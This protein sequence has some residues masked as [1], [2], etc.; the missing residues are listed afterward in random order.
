M[1]RE[2]LGG[3]PDSPRLPVSRAPLAE[4][5]STDDRG[6]TP[7]DWARLMGWEEGT[8]LISAAVRRARDEVAVLVE[9]EATLRAAAVT[10]A[11]NS[12]LARGMAAAVAM[13][14]EDDWA[15]ACA[16]VVGRA[17][18]LGTAPED[19]HEA[20][21]RVHQADHAALVRAVR[22][23]PPGH[24]AS[25]LR[26]DTLKGIASAS[27]FADALV[28]DGRGQLT[29]LIRA[30]RNGRADVAHMLL[31]AGA[32]VSC[33]AGDGTRP[34]AEAC[35]AGHDT[36]AK[37]LAA[38][39]ADPFEA[40]ADG[41]TPLMAAAMSDKHGLVRWLLDRAKA[42]TLAPTVGA[43]RS[44]IDPFVAPRHW[45]QD[46]LALI[47]AGNKHGATA[48]GLA[49]VGSL[50][51]KAIAATTAR[52]EA[53]IRAW[54][55]ARFQRTWAACTACGERMANEDMPRH[56]ARFCEAR[57]V[58]TPRRRSLGEGC[59]PPLTSLI[60]EGDI[61]AV[62]RRVKLT[63][64]HRRSKSGPEPPSGSMA[65][66]SGAQ[67]RGNGAA[68][69]LAGSVPPPALRL[70]PNQAVLA[71]ALVARQAMKAGRHQPLP[72]PS[73]AP[74][75]R[76]IRSLVP[77]PAAGAAPSW[78]RRQSSEASQQLSPLVPSSSKESEATM[79][80]L[81]CGQAI[82]GGGRVVDAHVVSRCLMRMVPCRLGCGET[83]RAG[84][85]Q[86]HEGTDCA[87][88]ESPCSRCGEAVRPGK[89]A[90][91]EQQRCDR[92][93]VACTNLC[94]Q[95]V[96]AGQLV[97]HIG[98]DCACRLLP[99]P[100]NCGAHVAAWRQSEHLASLC[101]RRTVACQFDGCGAG[102]VAEQAP[103]HEVECPHRPVGCPH[104]GETVSH[105][106]AA[107][108]AAL[109]DERPRQCPL[110]CGDSLPHGEVERHTALHCRHRLVACKRGCGAEVSFVRTSAHDADECPLRAVD[111]PLGCGDV[112]HAG[113][114]DFHTPVCPRRL[115][116]CELDCVSCSRRASSWLIGARG[117]A[118]LQLCALHGSSP[119]H[120]SAASGDLVVLQRLA[121]S[122]DPDE[123]ERANGTGRVPL[124]VA[125]AHGQVSAV[126]LLMELGAD[127]VLASERGSMPLLEA[128]QANSRACAKLLLE[129][130]ASPLAKNSR[131]MTPFRLAAARGL[132]GIL[133]LF[134][135]HLLEKQELAS[136]HRAVL[137][138]DMLS[139][140]V[141]LGDAACKRAKRQQQSDSRVP[142]QV[143]TAT[144]TEGE[145]W[146]DTWGLQRKIIRARRAVEA[147]ARG[148]CRLVASEAA[149]EVQTKQAARSAA[150]DKSAPEADRLMPEVQLGEADEALTP[151][152]P[153]TRT[154]RRVSLVK[155]AAVLMAERS[156]AF[157]AAVLGLS[158]AEAALAVSDALHAKTT[159]RHTLL[160]FAAACGS[161]DCVGL[162]LRLGASPNFSRRAWHAAASMIQTA[163]RCILGKRWSPA[164][165][166][167]GRTR[168]ERRLERF[169]DWYQVV[170]AGRRLRLALDQERLPLHEAAFSGHVGVVETLLACRARP[171]LRSRVLAEPP[172]PF[173]M[174]RPVRLL[175][176][177]S[178]V[179]TQESQT[180][181]LLVRV[182]RLDAVGDVLAADDVHA[183]RDRRV[184]ALR[185][186]G[187]ASGGVSSLS[188]PAGS[189]LWQQPSDVIGDGRDGAAVVT[190]REYDVPSEARPA[191]SRWYRDSA[192]G[193]LTLFKDEG[194]LSPQKARLAMPDDA[195]VGCRV[196]PR[197]AFLVETAALGYERLGHRTFSEDRGWVKNDGHA[198]TLRA[199][200][201]VTA[202]AAVSRRR[203]ADAGRTAMNLRRTVAG[204][205]KLA[206][207]MSHALLHDDSQALADC[208]SAGLPAEHVDRASG[209]NFAT[210]A[211]WL[212]GFARDPMRRQQRLLVDIVVDCFAIEGRQLL[213]VQ[214][215][216]AATP[217]MAAAARGNLE[218]LS[219][220]LARGVSVDAKLSP[221]ETAS[222]SMLHPLVSSVSSDRLIGA[223]ALHFAAACGRTAAL[224]HLIVA[225]ADAS[226]ATHRGETPGDLAVALGHG[227]LLAGLV[228]AAGGSSLSGNTARL[229]GNGELQLA[230]CEWG[231]G[232]RVLARARAEHA[233]L[234]PRRVVACPLGCGVAE[235]FAADVDEHCLR[236]C[237][238]RRCRCPFGCPDVLSGAELE[239]HMV[240]CPGKLETPPALRDAV[241]R[242]VP[243]KRHANAE[244]D[245]QDAVVLRRAPPRGRR[246]AVTLSPGG[247]RLLR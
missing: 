78:R 134:K 236:A 19:V 6:R 8:V 213:S 109:C 86:S 93:M 118:R 50:S 200:K 204:R 116:T 108:H 216:C 62:L 152:G 138:H 81:G 56:V 172:P 119:L 158:R 139:L 223:T 177:R 106:E 151:E 33:P 194:N 244:A 173:G 92:R 89:A 67:D 9:A 195:L 166:L 182:P 51:S 176:T 135:R 121:D 30:C 70:P 25:L 97:H 60:S 58:V 165:R 201:D 197:P 129:A 46:L 206:A 183:T 149:W 45:C 137:K 150:P 185:L 12:S 29:S 76:K 105:H 184:P 52:A 199:C 189:A 32:D 233:S 240:R 4:L 44:G 188:G 202:A 17:E 144:R 39:G 131:G 160:S 225:G 132:R 85:S 120:A 21:R 84:D 110:G 98:T 162:L 73:A 10:A 181:D 210:G 147:A 16:R 77:P 103:A 49:P 104:C 171:W 140:G 18:G 146:S 90:T 36:L 14:L 43:G 3:C 128:V 127:P 246:P 153:P 40:D 69:R 222:G 198:A 42:T 99:C 148:A 100:R 31:R 186:Q 28:S 15:A 218:V 38:A 169:R 167:T 190:D 156:H 54:K 112:L 20:V 64:Y 145:E 159:L 229:V 196:L 72:E 117:Q 13:P 217:L 243:T 174:Q 111:C 208:L 232:A 122:C 88:R 219:A 27:F 79:C 224:H 155:S 65:D 245:L 95:R 191:T 203:M 37:L 91:H 180:S 130:G 68:E 23:S 209:H 154:A 115:L 235:L 2:V 179:S 234:C 61:A 247:L 168:L 163:W 126:Q 238:S 226:A 80:P 71:R 170:R 237:A 221:S 26:F 142:R 66:V 102:V 157:G 1:L 94:G 175:I 55:A 63:A 114:L 207:A 11:K 124:S 178:V 136:M 215:P 133:D 227:A 83:V 53:R 242:A 96:E 22:H 41:R 48:L 228:A 231:C 24:D 220:V 57:A 143:V 82:S 59:P 113:A 212:G 34:L 7:L 241:I 125:C 214:A 205:Q 87:A 161:A 230:P 239:H 5:V 101:P 187:A 75:L 141:L 107:D 193:R 35:G 47:G 192:T 211:A 164:E 74:T 123:L